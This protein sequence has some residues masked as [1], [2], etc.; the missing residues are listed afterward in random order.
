MRK[1]FVPKSYILNLRKTLMIFAILLLVA[2]NVLTVLPNHIHAEDNTE[3]T[4][5]AD[6]TC[7]APVALINGSFEQGAARGSA[8]D[9]SGLYYYE[10]EVPIGKLLIRQLKYGTM[11]RIFRLL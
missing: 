11:H 9:G 10:S 8:Y 5:S 2:G 7:P 3:V 1:G 4:Q 6:T